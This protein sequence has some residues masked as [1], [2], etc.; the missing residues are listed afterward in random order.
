MSAAALI[1]GGAVVALM[2]D[3]HRYI[4]ISLLIAGLGALGV[5]I[6]ATQRLIDRP[7]PSAFGEPIADASNSPLPP[8]T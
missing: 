7:R 1:T 8:A 6:P 2:L 3:G 5:L 4:G